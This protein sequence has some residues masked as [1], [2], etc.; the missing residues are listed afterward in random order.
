[1][2][3]FS[4][5]I[6][7]SRKQ[8]IIRGMASYSIIWPLGSV[9]QQTIYGEEEYDFAKVARYGLYGCC[10]V[11]PTLYCWLK[12]ANT[13]WPLNTLR[14]AITK[15][16]VEQF[17][18]TP[19]AMSSF[20][21]GMTLLEGKSVEEATGE[22]EAKFLPTYKVGALIW[23]VIQTFNYTMVPEK[24]RIVFVSICSLV[25]TSFLAYMKHLQQHEIPGVVKLES[26]S[27]A[28]ARIK[29]TKTVQHMNDESTPNQGCI[30]QHQID[31]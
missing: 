25:W 23:P 18:Y 17:T 28:T 12:I 1:M 3:K 14:Y 10:Y 20:Y 16:V 31:R 22:V 29:T 5:I 11:A 19:F 26:E 4:K 21:F 13:I 15:G 30:A 2:T 9:V 8:P 27:A 24:N 7:F 6:A